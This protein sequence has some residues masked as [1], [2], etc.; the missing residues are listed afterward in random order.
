LFAAHPK[1]VD[2]RR[3]ND[4]YKLC[5]NFSIN[6]PAPEMMYFTFMTGMY[7][8]ARWIKKCQI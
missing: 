1:N 2:G 3:I 6:T 5:K 8:G 4:F 7:I